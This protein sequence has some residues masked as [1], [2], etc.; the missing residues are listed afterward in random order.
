MIGLRQVI[1]QLIRAFE[2]RC[3]E[4][5]YRGSVVAGAG[6]FVQRPVL[7]VQGQ[8][9]FETSRHGADD[10]RCPVDHDHCDRDRKLFPGAH[11][12]E[13]DQTHFADRSV[14]DKKAAHWC[15]LFLHAACR[16]FYTARRL[17]ED[18]DKQEQTK[19]DN[20]NK[21]PIPRNSLKPEVMVR[22]EMPL[23]GAE[24]NHRKHDGAQGD[25]KA[26]EPG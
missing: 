26:M 9:Q 2:T 7:H 19:P 12:A 1:A 21:V 6:K 3:N 23:H 10:T 13:I 22:F 14:I 11:S 5:S 8:R 17:Y 4:N 24:H 25:M 18:I 16:P 20:V 15:G